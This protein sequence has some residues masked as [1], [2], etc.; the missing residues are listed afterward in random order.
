M[1]HH[2]KVGG[3]AVAMTEFLSYELSTIISDGCPG[4]PN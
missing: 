4:T 1:C 3:N 2:G